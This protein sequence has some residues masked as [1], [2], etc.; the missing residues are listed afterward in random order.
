MFNI[1][2]AG[3]GELYHTYYVRP[4]NILQTAI[5]NVT[6]VCVDQTKHF[7]T[8]QFTVSGLGL[9]FNSI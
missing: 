4:M 5:F 2:S 9:I 8:S 1:R 7:Y 6:S 3:E